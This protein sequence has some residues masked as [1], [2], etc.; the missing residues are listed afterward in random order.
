M[1]NVILRLQGLR[2]V[3]GPEG[4]GGGSLDSQHKCGEGVLPG[5][6]ASQLH[7]RQPRGRL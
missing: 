1:S 5:A 2:P 7:H 3:L 6:A 4:G